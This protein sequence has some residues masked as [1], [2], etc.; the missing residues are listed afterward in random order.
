VCESY[1]K[2]ATNQLSVQ[3]L[4]VSSE[5]SDSETV[6]YARGAEFFCDLGDTHR[7]LARINYEPQ[8]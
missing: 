1:Q 6:H 7:N 4:E 8:K 5:T 2:V 3:N